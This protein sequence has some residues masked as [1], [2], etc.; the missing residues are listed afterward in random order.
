M[1]YKAVEVKGHQRAGNH[2]LAYLINEN[3]FNLPNFYEFFKQG[4]H[5]FGNQHIVFKDDVLY[6]YIHRDFESTAK[7]LFK[8]RGRF[9]I[10]T[11]NIDDLLSDKKMGE[12]ASKEIETNIA[13]DKYTAEAFRKAGDSINRKSPFTYTFKN[14]SLRE[15]HSKHI[16]SWLKISRPNLIF[17]KYEDLVHDFDNTM[18][19]IAEKLGSDNKK[20][21]NIDKKVGVI[22]KDED[23]L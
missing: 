17:I 3:F 23:I 16:N 1:K 7:S 18:L 2:Y 4:S 9:C 22:H 6:I 12:Y 14:L 11:E 21:T 19:Y 13:L 20:F 15:W 5:V 10:G 8:I